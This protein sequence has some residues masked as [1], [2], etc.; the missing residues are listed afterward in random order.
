MGPLSSSY[1]IIKFIK[2]LPEHGP[3]NRGPSPYPSEK[4]W[5][6]SAVHM[7]QMQ[8][9]RAERA[10]L[11]ARV[12][13]KELKMR[14]L[15]ER[16]ADKLFDKSAEMIVDSGLPIRDVVRPRALPVDKR[17]NLILNDLKNNS[18][19]GNIIIKV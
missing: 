7:K 8:L 1:E 12:R 13:A 5:K 15:K 14:Q 17:V 10:R 9:E 19:Q 11:R 6:M 3:R 2:T 4:T 16:I 18:E